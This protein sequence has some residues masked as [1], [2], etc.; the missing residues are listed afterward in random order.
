MH[1]D[2]TRKPTNTG[3]LAARCLAGSEIM[4]HG[5]QGTEVLAPWTLPAGEHLPGGLLLFPDEEAEE[6]CHE[7]L[8]NG[9][10]RLVV[11]DGTWRQAAKMP[12]RIPWMMDLPRVRLPPGKAT[13][14]LL[15]SEPKVGGLATL[16]AIA[17]AFGI[18]EGPGFQE[19]LESIFRKMVDRTLFS[20]GLLPPEKVFGGVPAAYTAG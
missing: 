20:R 18:L 11:P 12:R 13:T 17:R 4:V 3:Q 9:P 19:E 5:I 15:R 1:R 2:E 7:H 16:E 6:L 14:Y 8:N 10:V